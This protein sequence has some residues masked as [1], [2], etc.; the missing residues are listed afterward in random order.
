MR[1]GLLIVAAIALAAFLAVAVVLPR[2]AVNEAH[3]A[4][5]VLIEGTQSA[6]H[7]VS[8]AA[9]K[10]G[11]LAGAGK[12]VKLAPKNDPKHGE[13]KWLV[14][15]AGAIRG[16][17]EKNAIEISL[18][19]ALKSGKVNWTCRGFPVSAMPASCGGH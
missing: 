8:A 15:D 17:N 6:Q 16:W 12:G 7:D 9:E 18:I 14:S 19:P 10:A 13:M 1:I 3:G 11:S 4:A 5:Q 2:M